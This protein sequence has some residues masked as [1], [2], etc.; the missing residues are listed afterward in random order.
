MHSYDRS[1]AIGVLSKV[2]IIDV[3][4]THLS[5]QPC[6]SPFHIPENPHRFTELLKPPIACSK[7]DFHQERNEI[8]MLGT[9]V[10]RRSCTSQQDPD[11]DPREGIPSCVV[12]W[13][14]ESLAEFL[15]IRLM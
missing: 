5:E 7:S 12:R 9:G 10:R 8:A 11:E 13:R 14:L 15:Y 1:E 6:S 3:R 2:I 4:E